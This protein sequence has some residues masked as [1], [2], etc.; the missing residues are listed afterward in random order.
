MKVRT[1][2]NP[3][4]RLAVAAAT[5]LVVSLPALAAGARLDAPAGSEE[6]ERVRAVLL[7]S[8]EE[9]RAPGSIPARWFFKTTL[10]E[11]VFELGPRS[12]DHEPERTQA[13]TFARF[14]ALLGVLLVSCC[15]F[16]VL[17]STRGH[18]AAWLACMTL[19][20]LPP[21]AI[22][23]AILRP[24]IPATVASL[25]ALA[26]L[27]AGLVLDRPW[28]VVPA[29][30]RVAVM[31]SL[32]V[33]SGALCGLAAAFLPQPWWLVMIP[34]AMLMLT[35][36]SLT[37]FLARKLRRRGGDIPVLAL[38]RRMAF[39]LVA[40]LVWPALCAALL[41]VGYE[42]GTPALSQSHSEVVCWPQ[43]WV[44]RAPLLVL[45]GLGTLRLLGE[46]GRRVV[47][48]ARLGPETVFLVFAAVVFAHQVRVG[49]G[50]DAMLAAVAL[51]VL[52]GEGAA[53]FVQAG[54]V[55][56]AARRS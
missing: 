2:R 44:A 35:T 40:M 3:L 32:I 28:G 16:L 1:K 39:W 18:S 43:T 47:R 42:P 51:A 26:V 25:L 52:V 12:L 41:I 36:A 19:A 11:R 46:S 13:I 48:G 22:E 31:A 55:G 15:L 38:G 50:Y 17:A 9:G 7:A 6:V 20:A 10:P 23:G 33:A 34:S 21:I 27:L 45:A 29:M 49:V 30:T 53:G 24:E 5:L 56:L 8:P 37:I 54:I 14:V 4:R